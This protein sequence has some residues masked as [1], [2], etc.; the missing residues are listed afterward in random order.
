VTNDGYVYGQSAGTAQNEGSDVFGQPRLPSGAA[1][2]TWGAND[3]TRRRYINQEDLLDAHLIDL[4][5]RLYDPLLGKFL[6]PDPVIADQNDSQSWNAYAYSHNNP[7]SDEDPTGLDE[8]QSNSTTT[9]PEQITVKAPLRIVTIHTSV[10]AIGTTRGYI[11]NLA[12]KAVGHPG[13][14]AAKTL[15]SMGLAA[16]HGGLT[17]PNVDPDSNDYTIVNGVAGL[18]QVAVP[19]SSGGSAGYN[20]HIIGVQHEVEQLRSEGMNI[21]GI[22]VNAQNPALDYG[23]RYD[24]V[25]Q[26]PETSIRFG[27]EVK[28]SAQGMFRINQKQF[29][30]DM[31]T[32]RGGTISSVGR[33]GGVMYRGVCFACAPIEAWHTFSLFQGLKAAG[34]PFSVTASPMPGN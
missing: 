31:A 8:E 28:T 16:V 21:L 29:G 13:S 19:V 3:V 4:N 32:V 27:V 6:S 5:A 10:G 20:Q 14:T 24:I 15:A 9:Q 12:I 1:D 33:I 23:R 25:A 11:H 17:T 18:I 2:A 7:M 30:F 22:E 26:N 34:V